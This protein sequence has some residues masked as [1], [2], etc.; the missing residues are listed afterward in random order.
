MIVSVSANQPATKKRG[1]SGFLGDHW[2]CADAGALGLKDAWY[3]A[4]NA[5]S[6]QV[7]KNCGGLNVT[8]EFVPMIIGAWLAKKENVSKL[9]EEWAGANVHYLLGYNEPDHGNGHNHPHMVTPALAAS[10]WPQ[11]Q[12]LAKQF[13]PPLTLVSPAVA[14]TGETG[15]TDAWDEHGKSQWLDDFL[16]NCSNVSQWCDPSEIKYIAMH[17]Y[18]GNLTRLKRQ[19]SGAAKRYGRKVW[20]TEFAITHWG[21]PPS[22]EKQDV[23]L[24]E[25]LPYLDS[26]DDVFRYA[27]F[28]G[29]NAPNEQNGGSNLLPYDSD[30]TKLTSTGQI[31][32]QRET[33]VMV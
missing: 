27:W 5:G 14:S 3:Y 1:Y 26:S 24:K 22:R 25:A 4:W 20:L 16:G 6:Q 29:R 7:I 17:D 18:H 31:Y 12:K 2:T 10:D 13:D 33:S 19:I 21:S 32:A 23:F 8:A 15:A 11:V 28:S 9:K 30:S